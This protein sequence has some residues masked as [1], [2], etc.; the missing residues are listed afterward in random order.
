MDTIISGL[1][2]RGEGHLALSA[3]GIIQ[4]LFQGS[5]CVSNPL[6][7]GCGSRMGDDAQHE[8]HA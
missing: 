3:W 7:P 4:N 5:R 8:M 1:L 6:L 2:R